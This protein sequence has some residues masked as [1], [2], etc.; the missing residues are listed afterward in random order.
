V[1]KRQQV[2]EVEYNDVRLKRLE[3]EMPTIKVQVKDIP[4]TPYTTAQAFLI[5]Q[6]PTSLELNLAVGHCR[7]RH[8]NLRMLAT[9][10]SIVNQL[11]RRKQKD[12]SEAMMVFEVMLR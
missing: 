9:S 11:W 8:E 3:N 1:Y 5:P 2:S 7:S 6:N 12:H 10:Y 4:C